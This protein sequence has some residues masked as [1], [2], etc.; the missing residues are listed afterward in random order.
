M[1][2]YTS[3]GTLFWSHLIVWIIFCL[4]LVQTSRSIA[5]TV[6]YQLKGALDF[7]DSPANAYSMIGIPL[8]ILPSSDTFVV[9][10][11]FFGGTYNPAVWRLFRYTPSTNTYVEITGEGQDFIGFGKGWWIIASEATSFQLVGAPTT[12][13]VGI[14]VNPGWNLIANPYA[15]T[16]L[17]WNTIATNNSNQ[18]LSLSNN[19]YYFTSIGEYTISTTLNVGAAYWCF[20]GANQAGFLNIGYPKTQSLSGSIERPI[21]SLQNNPPPPLPPGAFLR[22]LSPLEGDSCQIGDTLSIVWES[23]GISPEGMVSTVSIAFSF[24]GG[25]HF[26]KIADQIDNKGIYNYPIL[27]LHRPHFLIVRIA[28][29]LYPEIVAQSGTIHIT[30]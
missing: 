16:A 30:K 7:P 19:I 27:R 28:S 21:S 23:K 2:C 3:K 11:D 13:D 9:L 8:L 17:S 25:K 18:N 22:I 10:K 4:F 20:V 14:P 24:D 6:D 29:E 1:K 15:D 12:S 26:Y 5:A